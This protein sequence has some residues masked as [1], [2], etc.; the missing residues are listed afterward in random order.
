MLPLIGYVLNDELVSI[1]I[2]V[3]GHLE[4]PKVEY[5]PAAEIGSGLLG[6]MKRTLEL[7]VKVVEPII[8]MEEKKK[9]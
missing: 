9:E 1:A 7:P 4:D 6:I 3:T 8:P 5:L 2:K